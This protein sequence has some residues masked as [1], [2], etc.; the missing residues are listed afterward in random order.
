MNLDQCSFDEIEGKITV[1]S[2]H[3]QDLYAIAENTNCANLKKKVEQ[4]IV[5]RFLVTLLQRGDLVNT[6]RLYHAYP[7]GKYNLLSLLKSSS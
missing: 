1:I 7:A 6:A 4:F 2:I 5:D 3:C